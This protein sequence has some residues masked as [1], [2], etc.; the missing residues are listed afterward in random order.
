MNNDNFVVKLV[1]KE[2]LKLCRKY[3]QQLFKFLLIKSVEFP[4]GMNG[5]KPPLGIK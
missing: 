5:S 3:F 1:I 4:V 2:N